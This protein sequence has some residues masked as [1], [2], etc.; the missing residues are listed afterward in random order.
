MQ[1][2]R[3]SSFSS[4]CDSRDAGRLPST[5]TESCRACGTR[6][7]FERRRT[8]P[9]CLLRPRLTRYDALPADHAPVGFVQQTQTERVQAAAKRQRRDRLEYRDG[10]LAAL[11]VV[12]RN[13]RL[14]VVD[15][16]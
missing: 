12:A 2:R 15:V 8:R 7:T 5:T 11:Q 1:P 13:A 3:R 10:V 16:V 9:G 4:R 14:D 6:C